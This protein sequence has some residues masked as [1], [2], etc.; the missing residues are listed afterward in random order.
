MRKLTVREVA[1]PAEPGARYEV[2]D[3]AGKVEWRFTDRAPADRYVAALEQRHR[4]SA[5]RVT[6]LDGS[7]DDGRAVYR[8]LVE[9]DGERHEV[10]LEIPRAAIEALARKAATNKSRRATDGPASAYAR[11]VR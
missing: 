1:T 9:V 11:K 6:R 4:Y 7:V 3:D 5:A 2:V 10:E 8:A